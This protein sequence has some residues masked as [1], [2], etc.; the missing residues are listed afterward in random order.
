MQA[1]TAAARLRAHP[2]AMTWTGTASATT[3]AWAQTT[4]MPTAT[5][6]AIILTAAAA[7]L[8]AA[9]AEDTEGSR[10]KT[11]EGESRADVGTSGSAHRYA[12]T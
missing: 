11:A 7:V 10:R 4:L 9:W 5:A 3:A 8:A 1:G 6:C 2:A 12:G